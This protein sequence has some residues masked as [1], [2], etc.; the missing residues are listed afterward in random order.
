MKKNFY[1][2]YLDENNLEEITETL[3]AGLPKL[4]TL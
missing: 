1:H 4:K 3:F 2:R